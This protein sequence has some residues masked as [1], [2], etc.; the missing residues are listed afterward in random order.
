MGG[1][2][3]WDADDRE[4]EKNGA[5]RWIERISRKDMEYGKVSLE[6]C[7]AAEMD[8]NRDQNQV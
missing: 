2:G 3:S 1:C 7:M 8:V 5:R 6:K 4:N